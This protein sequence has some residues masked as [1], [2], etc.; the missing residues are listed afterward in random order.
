VGL[1]ALVTLMPGDNLGEVIPVEEACRLS[2]DVA[3][4]H[5]AGSLGK[6]LCVVTKI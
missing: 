1:D 4:F 6:I 5:D 3:T 2:K